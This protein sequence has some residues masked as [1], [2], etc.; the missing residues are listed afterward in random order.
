M[1]AVRDRPIRNWNRLDSLIRQDRMTQE[2]VC[3]SGDRSLPDRRPEKRLSE[4]DSL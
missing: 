1:D 2:I 3:G 4:G